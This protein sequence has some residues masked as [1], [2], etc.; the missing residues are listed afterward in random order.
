MEWLTRLPVV[1]TVIAWLMRTHAWR[2]WQRYGDRR[3]N[4]LAAAVTYIAFLSLFPLLALGAAIAA[5]TLSTR[6]IANLKQ[7][8]AEQIPGIS[9]RLDLDSLVHNAGTVGLIGAVALLWAGL[10]WVDMLRTSIRALW[11]VDEQPGNL[12]KR[13]ALDIGR[14]VGL[15]AVLAVSIAASALSTALLGRVANWLGLAHHGVGRTVLQ[16][17]GIVIAVAVGFL[18]FFYLLTWLPGV[19]PRRSAVVVA[20]LIG[21]I[22][23]EVLKFLLSGYLSAVA[24]K[25]MYGAFGVPIALLLWINFINRLLLYCAAWTA[26]AHHQPAQ[27]QPAQPAQPQP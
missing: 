19:H 24:G 11:G 18:L 23:F 9:D 4:R 10:G 17:A 3:G 25:S 5:A 12:V 2:S 27:P 1:G 15:G 13:K 26:T 16:A 14:L 6:Q 7:K 8:I 21:A 22:G 20:A